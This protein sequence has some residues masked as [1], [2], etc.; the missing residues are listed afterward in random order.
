[1]RR[2]NGDAL[3]LSGKAVLSGKVVA[4]LLSRE[5]ERDRTRK[6]KGGT[7]H[8]PR[9]GWCPIQLPRHV[10]KVTA[11]QRAPVKIKDLNPTPYILH[12][13]PYTLH[14]TPYSI[15]LAPYTP[16]PSPFGAWWYRGD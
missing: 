6:K 7:Y 9:E 16:H 2:G 4:F 11:F 5:I 3:Y 10:R 15:N 1:M 8:Q 13:T 12:P 14:S